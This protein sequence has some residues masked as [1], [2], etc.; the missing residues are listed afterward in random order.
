MAL[1][2]LPFSSSFLLSVMI[3]YTWPRLAQ[4]LP[5]CLP[6]LSQWVTNGVRLL[7][8][9]CLFIRPFARCLLGRIAADSHCSDVAADVAA[10]AAAAVSHR[11]LM[12]I[13]LR[14]AEKMSISGIFSDDAFFRW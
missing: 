13:W 10:A 2:T 5:A 9:F 3:A 6:S 4:P 11:P 12:M 8:E 1:L 7:S 14:P